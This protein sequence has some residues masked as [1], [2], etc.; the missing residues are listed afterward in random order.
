MG[1]RRGVT[2]MHPGEGS[3]MELASSSIPSPEHCVFPTALQ[4]GAE[5]FP[6]KVFVAFPDGTTW[7]YLQTWAMVNAV[8]G[9]LRSMG[10]GHGDEVISWCVDAGEGLLIWLGANL[11]GAVYVP[12]N[13]ELRGSILAHAVNN[14]SSA[15]VMVCDP[16]LQGRLADIQTRRLERIVTPLSVAPDMTLVEVTPE[17]PVRPWD[18]AMILLTSGTTGPSKGVLCPYAHIDTT[19]E[20]V[21]S[22][23]WFAPEDRYLVSLPIFHAGGVFAVANGL[24]GGASIGILDRF[25]TRTFWDVVRATGST[26][27]TILGAMGQFLI[28]QPPSPRDRAHPLRRAIVGPVTKTTSE[29]AERFG[30]ELITIFN[31]TEASLPLRSDPN[32]SQPGVLG[33]ARAGVEVRVVNENDI[34]VPDGTAGELILRA[35][36]PWSMFAGYANSAEA[37]ATAWRNGWFHTGDAVRRARDGNY[38]FVDRKKDAIRRRGENISS[39]ELEAELTA[40]GPVA[41]AAVVAVDGEFSED[42]VLSVLAPLPGATI[43]P[44]ALIDYLRPRVPYYMIPRY[45]RVV[46]DLPRTA[47]NKVEKF[48][49]R[50]QGVT[51]DTWDREKMGIRVRSD[52]RRPVEPSDEGRVAG[53]KP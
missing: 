11:L 36:R 39:I 27:A 31:M 24:L 37:T 8:A 35:D 30:L 45:V 3:V 13:P 34:E 5:L 14:V 23:D 15:R 21:A 22:G 43:D 18:I 50:A 20:V 19:A 51:E 44:Q 49:L 9:R 48:R 52:S 26:H 16:H 53:A 47:S 12:L 2:R 32:P 42:E 17:R 33:K 6:D 1:L 7:T 40:Y 38:F 4:R 29:L 28:N 25:D 10:V 41:E 46:D